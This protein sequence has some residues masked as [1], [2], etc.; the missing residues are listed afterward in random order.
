M[1][2]EYS[3]EQAAG[4]LGLTR[5][6]VYRRIQTGQLPASVVRTGTRRFVVSDADIEKYLAG[7]LAAEEPLL[8]KASVVATKLGMSVEMVRRLCEQGDL[9]HRRGPGRRG[10]P[11]HYYITRE[12]VDEYLSRSN[13]V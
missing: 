8:L 5:H 12:S 13:P 10:G 6:Q 1:S 4:R 2:E 9:V 7:E 3:V 11:G